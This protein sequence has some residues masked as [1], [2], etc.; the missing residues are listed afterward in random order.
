MEPRQLLR[1]RIVFTHFGK[2]EPY[3][4]EMNFVRH[5]PEVPVSFQWGQLALSVKRAAVP[6]A[7]VK[8]TQ[9]GKGDP[10]ARAL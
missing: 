7:A 1:G 10:A 8:A 3:G 9:R 4:A 2:L 5:L 6:S